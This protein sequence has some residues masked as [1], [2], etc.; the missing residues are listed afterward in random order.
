MGQSEVVDPK[1]QT[2]TVSV[3]RCIHLAG[4]LRAGTSPNGKLIIHVLGTPLRCGPLVEIQV[5]P[6]NQYVRFFRSIGLEMI[7]H[8]SISTDGGYTYARWLAW[9]PEAKSVETDVDY[10]WSG[11]A[12]A[13]KHQSDCDG[14]EAARNVKFGLRAVS[15]RLRDISDAY[16]SQ[17]TIA[18]CQ[19]HEPGTRFKNLDTLDLFLSIHSFLVEM[20]ALRDYLAAF[21][22]KKRYGI[23]DVAKMVPLLKYCKGHS[24]DPIARRIIEICDEDASGGWM[25][26]MSKL[27]N[28]IVHVAPITSRTS[29]SCVTSQAC[30][31][32]EVSLPTVYLGVQLP[33]AGEAEV[34]ALA[35]CV[36]LFRNM[37]SFAR[38][39][40]LESGVL[41][42]P[43]KLTDK[44]FQ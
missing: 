35:H 40:A 20:G 33:N 9:D 2:R 26:R 34:D 3:G 19:G 24:D 15:S 31:I 32:G 36:A 7:G 16:G 43:I 37:F 29:I 11:I 22:A 14:E 12:N 10:I 30:K 6:Q 13:L 1:V 38:L 4:G 23:S 17:D 41:P 28:I 21:V 44:G 27:R 5:A 25:A 42:R 8:E 39:V 18:F